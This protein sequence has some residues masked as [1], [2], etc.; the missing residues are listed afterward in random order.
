MVT[1]ITEIKRIW[2]IDILVNNAGIASDATLLKMDVEKWRKVM[3]TNLDSVYH[4]SSYVIHDM[5]LMRQIASLRVVIYVL[6]V[7]S[8]W[9]N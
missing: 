6:M 5:W 1:V 2:P 9:L 3:T 7:V 8:I 4:V